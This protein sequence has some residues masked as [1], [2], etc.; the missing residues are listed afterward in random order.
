MYMQMDVQ[1]FEAGDFVLQG[2]MTLPQAKMA[3]KTYGELN[4][5]KSNVIIYPSWYSGFHSDN[6]WLIYM[7]G[8][9]CMVWYGLAQLDLISRMGGYYQ[10]RVHVDVRM[11]M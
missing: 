10:W 2:G 8:I 11:G 6:E 1:I 5:D 9:F 4:S 3:Y 7:L